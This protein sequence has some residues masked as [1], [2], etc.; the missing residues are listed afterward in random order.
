MKQITQIFSEGEESSFKE[1][2][3]NVMITIIKKTCH[4]IEVC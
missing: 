2:G 4:E 1:N 3:S